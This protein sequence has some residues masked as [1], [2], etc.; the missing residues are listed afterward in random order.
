MPRFSVIIPIKPGFVPLALQRFSRGNWPTEGVELL[1]AKGRAPSS[2]RNLA[3]QMAQGSIL[4]F[5]DD[6]SLVPE[7]RLTRLAELMEDP[8]IVAVGGPSLTPESDSL[9]QRTIGVLLG[10]RIGA[11]AVRARYCSCGVLRDSS[12]QELILC[13]LAIRRDAF[14][15]LGG[16]HEALYPNEENELLDRLASLGRLVHDPDLVVYRSQRESLAAFIR[17]MFRYGRG[18]GQQTRL[19]GRIPLVSLA[20]VFL[21][22][23]LFLLI[24]FPSLLLALPFIVYVAICL[25]TGMQA[26]R[27]T[28]DLRSALLLPPLVLL[29]HLSNGIGLISGLL[30]GARPV[31]P[32]AAREVAVTRYAGDEL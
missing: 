15:A 1:V 5:I 20:P 6:D 14:L 24:L 18:R 4:Y 17:Q 29:M 11:G 23:Y 16:L 19:T 31:D 13:N 3:A 8:T 10:S 21:W 26:V 27:Q 22:L 7:D 28:G 9:L 25:V 2:Q 32:Q 12:E 30:G